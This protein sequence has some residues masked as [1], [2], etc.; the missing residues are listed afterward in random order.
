MYPRTVLR[1]AVAVAGWKLTGERM[2]ACVMMSK[3]R[4]KRNVCRVVDVE[5]E[6]EGKDKL[7]EGLPR[8]VVA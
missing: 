4:G 8:R 1:V 5:V 3:L 7:T 6:I 2:R